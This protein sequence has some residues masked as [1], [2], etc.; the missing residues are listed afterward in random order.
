MLR[1]DDPIDYENGTTVLWRIL[2]WLYWYEKPGNNNEA[3]QERQVQTT[4]GIKRR[5][6]PQNPTAASTMKRQDNNNWLTVSD[7]SPC[8]V[9]DWLTI[10]LLN[11]VYWVSAISGA[12]CTCGMLDTLCICYPTHLKWKN[13]TTVIDACMTTTYIVS[14]V[15]TVP[16]TMECA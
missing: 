16:E 14:H 15:I 5:H 7:S 4:Y 9:A 11:S 13:K 3:Q 6:H 10:P 1:V 12:V 8:T 2:V